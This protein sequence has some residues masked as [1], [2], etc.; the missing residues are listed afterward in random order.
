[1]AYI[2]ETKYGEVNMDYVLGIG[3]FNLERWNAIHHLSL[4]LAFLFTNGWHSSLAR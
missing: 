1:M 4:S 3:G 2:Q